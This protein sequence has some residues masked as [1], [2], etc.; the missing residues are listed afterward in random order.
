[1]GDAVIRVVLTPV[2][3][4]RLHIA[5]ERPSDPNFEPVETTVWTDYQVSPCRPVRMFGGDLGD[6]L[7]IEVDE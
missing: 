6:P 3:D 5:I 4:H 7:T 2:G 1:M